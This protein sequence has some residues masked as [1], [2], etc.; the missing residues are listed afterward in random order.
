MGPAQRFTY[1]L[2]RCLQQQGIVPHPLGPLAGQASWP[3]C[4]EESTAISKV[5]RRSEK[6]MQ[7]AKPA[8]VVYD[9]SGNAGDYI[10]MRRC[11]AWESMGSVICFLG[12]ATSRFPLIAHRR[13]GSRP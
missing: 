4:T 12:T 5:T 3:A 9:G 10:R 8:C 11:V 13:V 7:N 6:G 1:E 2:E